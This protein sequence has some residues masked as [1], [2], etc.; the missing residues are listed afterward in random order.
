MNLD[1]IDLTSRRPKIKVGHKT[2][3]GVLFLR[4]I[5]V[6]FNIKSRKRIKNVKISSEIENF[7]GPSRGHFPFH[8]PSPSEKEMEV[9][10]EAS[11]KL[12]DFRDFW[13]FSV[14]E[15]LF[16]DSFEAFLN[17]FW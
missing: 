17:V 7:F 16:V 11:V 6:D 2:T 13:K 4:N 10:G 15:G 12:P 14:F 5:I 8:L 1:E 3:M 9:E